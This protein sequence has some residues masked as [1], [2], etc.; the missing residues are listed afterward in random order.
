MPIRQ[1]GQAPTIIISG[2]TITAV[3]PYEENWFSV[4]IGA[5]DEYCLGIPIKTRFKTWKI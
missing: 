2:G 4:I 5:D 1:A 3:A